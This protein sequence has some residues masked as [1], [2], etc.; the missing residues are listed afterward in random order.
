MTFDQPQCGADAQR[1]G[2]S[3]RASRERSQETGAAFPRGIGREV[4]PWDMTSIRVLALMNWT[5]MRVSSH[6]G[7]T[8]QRLFRQ[9]VYGIDRSGGAIRR[10]SRSL[11]LLLRLI[12]RLKTQLAPMHD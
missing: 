2:V 11:P 1:A 7:S 8:R 3:G 10:I 4:G 5:I 12:A 9:C 6:R